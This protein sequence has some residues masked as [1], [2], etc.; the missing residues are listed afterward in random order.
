M[1]VV[2]DKEAEAGSV[3]LRLRTNENIGAVALDAFLA[4]VNRLNMERSQELWS[5]GAAV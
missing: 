2:G 5:M 1:L 3:S 4:E